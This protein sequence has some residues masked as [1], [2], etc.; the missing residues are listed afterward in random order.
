MI[1]IAGGGPAGLT[2]GINLLD[3]GF[4]VLIFDREGE[5]GV[6]QHC[7][8]IVSERFVKLMN[9]PQKL[10]VNKLYGLKVH[11]I[12]DEYIIR[13]SVPKA[14]IIDRYEYEKWLGRIFVDKGGIIKF[15]MEIRNMGRFKNTLV[16]DARGAPIYINKRR[17]GFLP[18]IQYVYKFDDLDSFNPRLAH[19]FIARSINPDFFSWSVNIGGDKWK[20]GT[21]S[22]RNMRK[23]LKEYL[24]YMAGGK[25]SDVLY[26]YVI[27]GGPLKKF[28]EGNIIAIGDSAGQVKP[29]TGGGLLYHAVASKMLSNNIYEGRLDYEKDFYSFLGR[30]IHLQTLARKIFLELSDDEFRELVSVL[31]DKEL[32]NLIL[33]L[34]DMDFHVSSVWKIFK[35]L[36]KYKPL[37]RVAGIGRLMRLLWTYTEFH[38][39]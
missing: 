24:K 7:S 22:K 9:I 25:V 3:K 34:G 12:S 33:T 17:S 19:I 2:T 13:S 31:S 4:D 16:I 36:W 14:Y 15:N 5:V 18:A 28:R 8:G 38:N 29:T 32:S 23:I 10:I 30:E 6:P 35:D 20:I 26:G 39:Q 37:I 27:T 1:Q 21:A 11:H